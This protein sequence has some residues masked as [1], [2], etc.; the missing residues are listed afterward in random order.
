[1]SFSPDLSWSP[2]FILHH[3]VSLQLLHTLQSKDYGNQIRHNISDNRTYTNPGH[4]GAVNFSVDD[5]GTAHISIIAPNG[6]AASITST[7]NLQ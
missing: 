6:D 7:V 5:H 3:L 2:F 1:M 4:Y